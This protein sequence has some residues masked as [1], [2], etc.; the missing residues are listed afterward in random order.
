MKYEI[1]LECAYAIK[2]LLFKILH[3]IKHIVNRVCCFFSFTYVNHSSYL[4]APRAFNVQGFLATYVNVPAR[5]VSGIQTHERTRFD[6][7]QLKRNHW[8]T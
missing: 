8:F 6:I 1:I 7:R 4:E 3:I 5:H 2:F